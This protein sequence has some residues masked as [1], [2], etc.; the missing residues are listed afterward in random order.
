MARVTNIA[1]DGVRVNFTVS[2]SMGIVLELQ[3]V[4]GLN[5]GSV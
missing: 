1:R 2:V 5:L 3:L 4:L